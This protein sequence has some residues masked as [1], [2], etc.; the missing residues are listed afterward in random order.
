MFQISKSQFLN[1]E[2]KNTIYD[3]IEVSITMYQKSTL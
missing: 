3:L 2:C 1:T